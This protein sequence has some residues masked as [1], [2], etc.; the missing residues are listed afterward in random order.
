MPIDDWDRVGIRNG[1]V[2]RLQANELAVLF[3]QQEN[4]VIASAHAALIHLPQVREFGQER[5]GNVL[6][7]PIAQVG[8]DIVEDGG[9]KE[10]PWR[11][12]EGEEHGG[13]VVCD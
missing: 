7:G 8:E 4:G 5:S 1:D 6:N 11:E 10:Q 12:E 3:V 2:I 9:H 13:Y